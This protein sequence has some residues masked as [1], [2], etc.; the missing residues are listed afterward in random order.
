MGGYGRGLRLCPPRGQRCAAVLSWL[1]KSPSKSGSPHGECGFDSLLRHHLYLPQ[2]KGNV[3]E[4]DVAICL[5]GRE[6]SRRRGE[7]FTGILEHR[8]IGNRV[9][10]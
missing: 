1:V 3:R 2:V 10:T 4:N 9:T 6:L 7:L 8:L 5:R